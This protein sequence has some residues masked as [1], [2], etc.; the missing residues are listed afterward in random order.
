MIGTERQLQLAARQ[1]RYNLPED[2]EFVGLAAPQGR[3][4][5]RI[6]FSRGRGTTLDLP[7]SAET[8]AA[9]VQPLSS[10]HG[11]TPEKLPDELEHLRLSGGVLNE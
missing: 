5:I 6:R 11:L 4:I 9:L 2:L 7:L 3:E 10:L 8:L 1:C